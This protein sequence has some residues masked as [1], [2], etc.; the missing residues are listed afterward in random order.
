MTLSLKLFVAVPSAWKKIFEGLWKLVNYTD[1]NVFLYDKKQEAEHTNTQHL[2]FYLT[3]G[4]REKDTDM[5]ISDW[6]ID[7]LVGGDGCKNSGWCCDTKGFIEYLFEGF[8]AWV[9]ISSIKCSETGILMHMVEHFDSLHH[10]LFV[11]D[12][13]LHTLSQWYKLKIKIK[14]AIVIRKGHV[15]TCSYDILTPALSLVTESC[16][17]EK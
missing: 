7:N 3:C 5:K 4:S 14:K 8:G 17:T 1:K 10:F 16:M 12:L 11:S 6:K 2:L 13:D 9:N 15:K